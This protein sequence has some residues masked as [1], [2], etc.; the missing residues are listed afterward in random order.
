MLTLLLAPLPLLLLLPLLIAPA[1]DALAPLAQRPYNWG[2]DEHG[3]VMPEADDCK[4]VDGA[5]SPSATVPQEASAED[6]K[7]REIQQ[8]YDEEEAIL[9]DRWILQETEFYRN[10]GIDVNDEKSLKWMQVSML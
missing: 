7:A 4:S 10:R 3:K 8:V 2:R 9:Q 1:A 6:K 5:V